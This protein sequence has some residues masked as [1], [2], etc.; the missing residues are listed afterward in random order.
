M[1]EITPFLWFDTEAEEAAAALHVAL[2]GLADHRRDTLRGRR[3]G[4][5]G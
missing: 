4:A 5:G 1:N 3:A 2:P